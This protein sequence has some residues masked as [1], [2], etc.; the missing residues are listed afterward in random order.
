MPTRSRRACASTPSLRPRSTTPS[1]RA[2]P[3]SSP[4]NR[5]C[6][7]AASR[8]PRGLAAASGLRSLVCSPRLPPG[9]RFPFLPGQAPHWETVLD[10]I[11][12]CTRVLSSLIM[13][14]RKRR[15]RDHQGISCRNAGGAGRDSAAGPK[16]D[17]LRRSARA[18]LLQLMRS[19]IEV[20]AR[21]VCP[22]EF[23]SHGSKLET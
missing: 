22:I 8:G 15:E 5:S 9:S 12:R 2:R 14:K 13:A 20:D 6:G 7:A 21:S 10:T 23:Q 19:L 18:G 11:F 3:S 1:H 16:S 17:R 4:I